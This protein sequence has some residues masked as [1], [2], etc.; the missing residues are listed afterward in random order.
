MQQL[1]KQ[2]GHDKMAEV[3]PILEIN[4]EHEILKKL[5]HKEGVELFDIAHLLLDQA[6]LQEGMKIDDIVGFTKRL[7]KYLIK[8]L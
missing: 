6:K 8:A 2:M 7:N 1:L 4:P 3:K 5:R